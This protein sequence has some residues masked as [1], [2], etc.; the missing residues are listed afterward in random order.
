ML[1]VLG[2]TP[3]VRCGDCWTAFWGVFTCLDFFLGVLVGGLFFLRD[4]WLE[5]SF[6]AAGFRSKSSS[7]SE[8]RN[9]ISS[10]VDCDSSMSVL[11]A[12]D[13]KGGCCDADAESR[14]SPALGWPLAR[15]CLTETL[16]GS[17]VAKAV[18]TADD[19]LHTAA[20]LLG[21]VKWYDGVCREAAKGKVDLAAAEAAMDG[22]AVAAAMKAT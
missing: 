8:G 20:S 10:P 22:L 2:A 7:C 13:G 5:R 15:E 18:V 9:R 1:L 16:F 11:V 17:D 4:A 21:L 14:S 12:G 6:L 19:L 3:L